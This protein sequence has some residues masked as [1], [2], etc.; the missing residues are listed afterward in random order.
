MGDPDTAAAG[1]VSVL[2]LDE[3]A[4]LVAVLDDPL[5]SIAAEFAN[6]HGYAD[7][8]YAAADARGPDP[9][10]PAGGASERDKWWFEYVFSGRAEYQEYETP[11]GAVMYREGRDRRNEVRGGQM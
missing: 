1:L 10:F 9:L 11:W 7:R 2:G 6:R 8:L 5:G 4:G 3:A